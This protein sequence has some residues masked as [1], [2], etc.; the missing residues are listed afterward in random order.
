MQNISQVHKF[1]LSQK[2]NKKKKTLG[3]WIGLSGICR[4]VGGNWYLYSIISSDPWHSIFFH[5][6][7]INVVFVDNESKPV[8]LCIVKKQNLNKWIWKTNLLS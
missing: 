8:D 2:L 6:L 3:P 5:Y 7:K 4:K 1:I